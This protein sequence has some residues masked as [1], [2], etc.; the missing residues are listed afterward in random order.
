[1]V[2]VTRAQVSQWQFRLDDKAARATVR[3]R[4]QDATSG[5]QKL[6]ELANGEAVNG[7]RPVHTDRHLYPDRSAAEQ[8]ARARLASFNRETASVRLDLPG[9]TDLFAERSIAVEGFA[10][11]LDGQYLIDSVEQAFTASGW[12]TTVQCNGGK[13]GKVQAKGSVR[14]R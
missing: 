13:A 10:D 12:R 3:T 5:E 9:R 1:M 6:V 2:S 14:R 7:Q 11:G 8:A 4:Y